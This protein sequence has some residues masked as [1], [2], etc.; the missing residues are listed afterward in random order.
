MGALILLL[1]VTT[2]RIRN[3]VVAR[4]EA[5][6]TETETVAESPISNVIEGLVFPE[7]DDAFA[8]AE[9]VRVI[10]EAIPDPPE[11]KVKIVEPLPEPIDETDYAP[12]IARLKST[13]AERSELNVTRAS[14]LRLLKN[15]I[16]E[17]KQRVQRAQSQLT[18]VNRDISEKDKLARS[19]ILR[20]AKLEDEVAHANREIQQF[21][22][23]KS[24]PSVFSFVPY[25]G[26]TG[27]TKRPILI[28]LKRDAVWFRPEGVRL[29]KED[30][31]TFTENYNP[32]LAGAKTLVDYWAAE[33]SKT[34][35]GKRV[36]SYVLIVVR[37]SGGELFYV[38]R[39]YLMKLGVRN[40]YELINEDFPLSL[41]DIDYEA[42]RL[43]EEAI[44]RVLAQQERLIQQMARN[45][46]PLKGRDVIGSSQPRTIKKDY[47]D[48]LNRRGRRASDS[49][50]RSDS[51]KAR[52]PFDAEGAMAEGNGTSAGRIGNSVTGQRMA[53]G[54][55]TNRN[56][57]QAKGGVAGRNG[58][59]TGGPSVANGASRAKQA[60]NA[61]GVAKK[62][63]IGK[64]QKG[65]D[66]GVN[67]PNSPNWNPFGD[68]S[69]QQ[70][71][72]TAGNEKQGNGGTGSTESTEPGSKTGLNRKFA[73]SDP[74]ATADSSGTA[75]SGEAG[76]SKAIA[77]TDSAD[78]A[79][80]GG[81]SKPSILDMNRK[82]STTGPSGAA[83]LFNSSTASSN[84]PG[85]DVSMPPF[86][87]SQTPRRKLDLPKLR[88]KRRWGVYSPGATI[89]F[90]RKMTVKVYSDHIIFGDRYQL[91]TPKGVDVDSL[92]RQIVRGVDAK[93][94]TWGAPPDNFYWIPVIEYQV[95]PSGRDNFREVFKT[96]KESGLY[97]TTE[98]IAEPQPEK[99]VTTKK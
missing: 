55:P 29:S 65:V 61:A 62:A 25:D 47:S 79:A 8:E 69:G 76:S 99:P 94:K 89:G 27:T 37:P 87:A 91:K 14:Q 36:E 23:K 49:F 44:E 52:S 15:E 32:V 16:D 26:R 19:A 38:V 85:G 43:C 12:I 39:H 95:T 88:P 72:A 92:K 13:L 41:P 96:L 30:L 82:S 6:Q 66:N 80:A 33:D 97:S 53:G 70:Q 93:A 45:N 74:L 98:Y 7:P 42:K 63:G 1:I 11:D 64:K 46:T 75:D 20:Q 68:N 50:F 59:K 60:G 84:S 17:F 58:Q 35:N 67:D 31:E 21:A 24:Q 28:E 90:E 73:G 86:G 5:A 22:D 34:S 10:V 4:T 56:P 3:E 54:F 51:F 71:S 18:R 83:S 78:G 48:P 77:A 81:L 40:G 9:L 57:S 2:R